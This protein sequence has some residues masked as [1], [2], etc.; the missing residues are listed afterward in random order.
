MR[1]ARPR[2]LA[3]RSDTGKIFLAGLP[4]KLYACRTDLYAYVAEL[5]AYHVEPNA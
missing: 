4:K 5:N 1:S 2:T 3:T